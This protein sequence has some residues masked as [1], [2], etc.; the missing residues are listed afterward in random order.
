M[1]Y[2]GEHIQDAIARQSSKFFLYSLMGGFSASYFVGYGM[3]LDPIPICVISIGV[4]L[5]L[6]WQFRQVGWIKE[7][8]PVEIANHRMVHGWLNT[9]SVRE[10]HLTS[11]LL[12]VYIWS[13]L[14]MRRDNRIHWGQLIHLPLQFFSRVRIASGRVEKGIPWKIFYMEELNKDIFNLA[15]L[16]IMTHL[17]EDTHQLMIVTSR[18]IEGVDDL[19]STRR[20]SS[21]EE[22]EATVEAIRECH[23]LG[24]P[25]TI[26][27]LGLTQTEIQTL[28]GRTD[29]IIIPALFRLEGSALMGSIGAPVQNENELETY[30]QVE[31][32]R[33]S[34]LFI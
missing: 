14:S 17:V 21:G 29:M 12:Q 34:K 2:V 13:G 5:A 33:L 8:S 23:A 3:G 25:L 19:Y 27:A 26:M 20:F 18:D 7:E 24:N 16:M 9:S 11:F 31:A 28:S 10:P 4:T 22:Q 6:Y 15:Q 32:N 30:M 1:K